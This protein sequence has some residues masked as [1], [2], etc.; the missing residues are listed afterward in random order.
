MARR[1]PPARRRSPDSGYRRAQ[2]ERRGAP[3]WQWLLGTMVLVGFGYFL[4]GLSSAPSPA[5]EAKPDRKAMAGKQPEGEGQSRKK[6]P[7]FTFYTLL[8][9]KEVI[10]PEGEV[11]VRKRQERLGQEHRG[12]YFIQAGSFRT[13]GDADR[14]KARLAL[15]G[16]EARIQ[17]A[18]VKGAIWH[19]VRMGP[20]ASMNEVEMIRT[21]LRKH[22]IDSVV[23]TAKR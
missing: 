13:H 21:R 4:Y 8:P 23:Q 20:Y 6:E 18:K 11:K 1:S 10:V 7:R 14:L 22:R 5:P 19:R 3:W 17:R 15:L 16:V 2:R 12:Q 9:E